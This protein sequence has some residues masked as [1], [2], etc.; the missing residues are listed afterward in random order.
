MLIAVLWALP[1]GFV[2]VLRRL[3]QTDASSHATAKRAI[4]LSTGA[5]LLV[6]LVAI[7]NGIVLGPLRCFLGVPNCD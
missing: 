7:L 2:L 6:L 1:T 4:R 3:V 5:V